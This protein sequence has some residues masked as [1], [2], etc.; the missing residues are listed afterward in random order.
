MTIPQSRGIVLLAVG[1]VLLLEVVL[2]VLLL[3]PITASRIITVGGLSEVVVWCLLA[4]LLVASQVWRMPDRI[5]S[6]LTLGLSLWL[7]A[8]TADLLDE[9]LVQPLWM[10]SWMEDLTRVVG[11]MIVALAL[12]SLMRHA[13]QVLNDLERL[14]RIDPLTGL[15]NRRSFRETVAARI[16]DGFSLVL[17]DLDHFKTVN[18]RFGHDIGDRALSAVA[19]ALLDIT[20]A[21]SAVYRLGGEEFAV[22]SEALPANELEALAESLRHRIERLDV[23]PEVTLTLSAGAGTLRPAESLSDLM[24]RTDQALYRAKAQGRNRIVMAELKSAPIRCPAA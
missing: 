5:R 8:A 24:R 3:E 22:I 4:V 15:S 21:R 17:M 7:V 19:D 13:G 9:L 20:P 14:S 16:D 18:D 11:M 2:H 10:S 6:A 12:L 23:I 1:T